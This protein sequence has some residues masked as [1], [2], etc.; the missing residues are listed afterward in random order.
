MQAQTYCASDGGT[1]NI[2]NIDRV[3]FA[4][5]DNPSGDNNGYGDFT[6]LEASVQAGQ[7]Y[8]IT[9][10]P[11][12]PFF[13]RYR[14]RAWVDWNNDGVFAGN[15]LVLQRAGFGQESDVIAVPSGVSAGTKRMRVNM[16]AFTY[17]GACS[18]FGTGEV[19]DYAVVVSEQCL[20]DAG[21]LKADKPFL[22]FNGV[23]ATMRALVETAPV[24]PSGYELLYVLTSG[25]GLVIEQAAGVPSFVVTEAGSY[26]IHTLVYDPNTLDLSIVEFGSTTGFDVNGL[27]EQGGGSI[28]GALDVAGAQFRVD[29]PMAGTLSGGG[30]VCLSGEAVTLTATPDGNSN[31]PDGY[32]LAYVL[33]SGTELTIQQLGG[34]PEFEVTMGGLYTIHT[35]VFP[36]DLDLSV[37]VPGQTTGGD[38]LELLGANNICAS[39]DVAGAAFN[40]TAPMAGTLSGGGDVCLTGE[41]VTL[42]ATPDGNSNTPDGYSLAYV[43]TSGTELTIQQLGGAPEFDVTMGG[44]YTIHTFVFPS[45]LDLSVVVPGQTT[46]GDV[47]ELLGANNICASLDV[48]G[49]QFN[50]SPCD[51]E[52]LADAGSISPSDFIVCR[53]GGTAT[54]NGVPAGNAVVP[55]GYETLYVLTR[56]FNLV[57]RGVSSTPQFNVPQLGLYRIHTLV[58]DPSTLDLSIVVPGQTTGFDVNALLLQGGG[59]ICASLD[60]QGAPF[61]VV[62]PVLCSI[63]GN[64]NNG[65]APQNVEEFVSVTSAAGM[66]TAS[67]EA[68]MR[69]IEEDA[70]MSVVSV[71]PNPTRD[72]LNLELM[73][74]VETDL[75]VSVLNTLGQEAR[76]GTSLNLGQGPNRSTLDMSGLPAGAYLLRI[77]AKDKVLTHRFTKVD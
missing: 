36:S 56:G 18:T 35:F 76:P 37:V 22:C 53:F 38:V 17:R 62:G 46:G 29:D 52:C 21:T 60:V 70:P 23:D 10:D 77:T 16:S 15:E 1:G 39:L 44:L 71:F 4:G 43:L 59:D 45:D 27:L 6:Q 2:V 74:H 40:V 65:I 50:V 3:Q 11:S 67:E 41:A 55:A 26:T 72:F 64:F 69:T 58:Y 68:M 48:A 51:D 20:A 73:I 31:T 54:L 9:L 5:I 19:E 7:N 63:F 57:I 14:W 24:V 75:E 25:E 8:A 30:D 33:T 49:A 61:I 42:T 12:G 34:A 66:N 47:L 13:L 28:C 32:S